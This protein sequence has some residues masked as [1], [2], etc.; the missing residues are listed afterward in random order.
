MFDGIDTGGEEIL[1]GD[2]GLVLVI[3]QMC[4]TPHANGDE[5]HIFQSMSA[6]LG[7][8]CHFVMDIGSCENIV[9]TEAVQKL[10]VKTKTHSKPYKLAWLKNSFT[11]SFDFIFYWV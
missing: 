11:T 10:G 2:T 1:K 7:K 3:C 9:S 5:W 6:I 8:V 4:L